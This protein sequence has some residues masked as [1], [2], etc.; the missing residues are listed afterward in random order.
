MKPLT[1]MLTPSYPCKSERSLYVTLTIATLHREA[2][3]QLAEAL[4]SDGL[5]LLQQALKQGV[6][7]PEQ[8]CNL[9]KPTQCLMLI[10][11]CFSAQLC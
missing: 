11:L 10:S 9:L 3:D 2:T 7:K 6:L 4:R 5:K 1:S 8:S